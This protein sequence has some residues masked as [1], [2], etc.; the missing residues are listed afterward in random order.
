M[1]HLWYCLYFENK[2]IENNGS[3]ATPVTMQQTTL[4]CSRFNGGFWR[5]QSDSPICNLHVI[6]TILKVEGGDSEKWICSNQNNY[7]KKTKKGR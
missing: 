1:L 7:K 2:S 4:T 5:K 6:T 3:L